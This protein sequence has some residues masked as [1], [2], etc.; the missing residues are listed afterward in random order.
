MQLIVCISQYV[1][2]FIDELCW[3]EQDSV[4]CDK[5]RE[6]KLTSEEW[7]CT[8]TFLGLLSVH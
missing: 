5:I 8:N 3:E 1:N 2:V 4:K 6:L 7:E